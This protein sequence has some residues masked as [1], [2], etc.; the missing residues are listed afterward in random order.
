V[1][2]VR[3]VTSVAPPERR[4]PRL[5]RALGS[6][7]QLGVLIALLLMVGVVAAFH[8]TFVSKPSLLN[9]G[10]GAA[11][12]GIMA[13]GM[14]FLLSMREIDLSVGSIYGVTITAAALLITSHGWDPWL[15]AGAGVLMGVALGGLNGVFASALAVPTIIVTLGS[16]SMYR[17]LTLVLAD[18]HY[19]P[20]M[21]ESSFFDIVGG[22]LLGVPMSVWT[23]GALTLLLSALY[24]STR[25]GFVVRAI[26]SNEDAARLSGIPIGRVRLVT[27]MLMG[28]LCGIA[29]MLTLAFFQSADSN[30]GAGYELLVIAAAIIG[31]TGLS[32]GSGS[33]F[34][35]L[36]GALIISVIQGGLVQLAVDPNWSNFVTG[37]VIIAAVAVDAVVRRRRAAT[38]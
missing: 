11:L 25:Y 5:L 22:R 37:A 14:V 21:P 23:F 33:V 2:A 38:P 18:G 32:G 26:G 8:P 9:I 29:G 10:Q 24:R 12:Y 20:S 35:A 27:L 3:G 30:L 34:G 28:G 17:G 36:L 7:N 6:Y 4:A 16:L 31:G 19:V 1:S 13:L 15:A